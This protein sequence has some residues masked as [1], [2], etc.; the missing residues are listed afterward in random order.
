[1]EHKEDINDNFKEG[2]ITLY[3]DERIKIYEKK[4]EDLEIKAKALTEEAKENLR[5]GDKDEAGRLL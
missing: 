4:L 5:N 1:M 3:L 2:Q